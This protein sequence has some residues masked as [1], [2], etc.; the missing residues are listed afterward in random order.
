MS[1]L[2]FSTKA[3]HYFC[4]RSQ[5]PV[6]IDL[7]EVSWSHAEFPLKDAVEV[8]HVINTDRLGYGQNGGLGC[9]KHAGCHGQ[10]LVVEVVNETLSHVLF[11]VFHKMGSAETAD[12]RHIGDRDLFHIM[13]FH[14]F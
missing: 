8:G 3:I 14:I 12:L 1:F 11:E 5:I 7:A 13:Q 2:L 4:A 6:F 9:H 10:S